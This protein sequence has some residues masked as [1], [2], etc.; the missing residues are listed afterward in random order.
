M[1]AIA[2][3]L[4][5]LHTLS[6]FAFG[7][8]ADAAVAGFFEDLLPRLQNF[9]FGGLWSQ[10]PDSRD[11][12]S[13]L[14]PPRSLPHLRTLEILG[15]HAPPWTWFMGA[16]P[17]TLCAD[18]ATIERW[19]PSEVDDGTAALCPLASV[20]NLFIFARSASVF[21]P[22]NVARILR[23]SPHLETLSVSASAKIDVSW[24]A[25]SGHHPALGGLVHS[26]L[27]CIRCFG[28]IFSASLQF[29][30]ARLQRRPHFP[31]LKAVNC[32][33]LE[34]F[35][36][37]LETPSLVQRLVARVVDFVT[38]PLQKYHLVRMF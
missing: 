23:A 33:G 5:R 29:D 24:L 25:P 26:N 4:P 27:R 30:L 6:V 37:P 18:D 3:A 22:T 12:T 16:R 32:D 20:R 28:E 34:Y 9:E 7:A 36:T 35:I 11:F 14:S 38:T 13:S 17:L 1:A 15:G 21:T 2:A 19:L 8:V 31:R 10:D